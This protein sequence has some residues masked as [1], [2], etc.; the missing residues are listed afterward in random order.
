MAPSGTGREATVAVGCSS[1]AGRLVPPAWATRG[2]AGEG[3]GAG[4]AAPPTWA[5]RGDFDSSVLDGVA[6][7]TGAGA[8]EPGKGCEVIVP[9]AVFRFTICTPESSAGGLAALDD[10]GAAATG[11]VRELWGAA[12]VMGSG[13]TMGRALPPAS[14]WRRVGSTAARRV[15]LSPTRVLMSQTSWALS[16]PHVRS[17][18]TSIS[19]STSAVELS[20]AATWRSNSSTLLDASASRRARST[21]MKLVCACSAW[22]LAII[23][24]S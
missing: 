3:L 1:A 15:C 2:M 8:G 22:M 9:P 17:A 24:R 11:A 16:L 19:E 13:R 23:A 10:P 4:E 18:T 14:C 20:A 12:G 6:A 5:T 21:L 7:T